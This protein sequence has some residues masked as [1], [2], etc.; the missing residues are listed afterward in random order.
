M[1]IIICTIL[2]VVTQ[3]STM[4][5]DDTFATISSKT[6][7][8]NGSQDATVVFYMTNNRLLKAIRQIGG[9]GVQVTSSQ[10][11][12]VEIR[13]GNIYLSG[14]L[15]LKTA[16]KLGDRSY[17]YDQNKGMLFDSIKRSLRM[18]SDKPILFDWTQ[19]SNAEIDVSLLTKLSLEKNEIYKEADIDQI[20]IKK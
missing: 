8:E 19:N 6:W 13:Q 2:F 15:N 3:T 7:K 11:F 17:T 10:I 9:S 18:I 5:E 1:K 4:V 14:G 16:K 12:D 20:L